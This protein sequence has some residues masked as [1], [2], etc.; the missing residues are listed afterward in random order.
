M[1]HKRERE[2]ISYEDT[3]PGNKR[4]FRGELDEKKKMTKGVDQAV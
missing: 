4:S 1:R 3:E 2:T